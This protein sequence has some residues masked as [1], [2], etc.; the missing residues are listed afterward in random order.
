MAREAK[1]NQ[2]LFLKN[3]GIDIQIP[4]FFVIDSILWFKNPD[5]IFKIV[6][7]VLPDVRYKTI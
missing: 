4:T 2:E 6:K 1:K 5:Y 3:F 7:Y